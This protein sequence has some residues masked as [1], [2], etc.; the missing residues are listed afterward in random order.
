MN[1]AI[2][3][4]ANF[5][6]YIFLQFLVHCVDRQRGE[7]SGVYLCYIIMKKKVCYMVLFGLMLLE[8]Y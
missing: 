1:E 4:N 6:I 7:L 3:N 8:D 2:T 5:V